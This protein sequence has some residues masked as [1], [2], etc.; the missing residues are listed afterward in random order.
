MKYWIRTI[1][2]FGVFLIAVGVSTGMFSPKKSELTLEDIEAM[3]TSL[4][5]WGRWG[6]QDQVGALNL[7]TTEKKKQAAALVKR[8]ISV[9]LSHNV[10]KDPVGNSASFHHK[11]THTGLDP[12]SHSSGDIFSVQ[13][14]GYTQTHVDALC[15][16][17]YKGKM[18]NGFPQ[19]EV[20]QDGAGKLSVINLKN[21]I[22]TRGVLVDLP[23]LWGVDYLS[24]GKAI[25]AE[26]LQA[27]EK[28]SGVRIQSGDALL[29][30]TGRWVRRSEKGPWNSK[31]PAA[32]LHASCLPW[33]KERD[34]AIL[35]SE[36]ALDVYP[37]G[38]EGLSS[39]VHTVAIVAMG[40]PILDNCDFDELSRIANDL[41]RWEFLLMAA[42]L[43]VDGGTGSP[44]NPLAIF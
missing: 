21:G 13:Y 39:P 17:F 31:V 7:I 43:A 11:M 14:H 23:R 1:I 22:F 5:N 18:Y 28:K 3:M 38:V 20:T 24:D 16:F 4:S 41:G 35:G 26:D 37:S 27:W 12:N 34:V 40:V 33:L 36:L 2:L 32:G 8:G 10:I 25:Y 6:K 44:L 15:H 9:S 42:P 30:R 29:I 19:Q